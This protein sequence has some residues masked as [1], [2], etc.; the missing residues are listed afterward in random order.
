MTKTQEI[1]E[2]EKEIIDK[3]NI[4]I[5]VAVITMV[6]EFPSAI[7]YSVLLFNKLIWKFM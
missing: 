1:L 6:L 7:Y 4:L 2:K 3:E 5:V